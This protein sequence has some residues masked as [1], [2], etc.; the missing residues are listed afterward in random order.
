MT[1]DLGGEAEAPLMSAVGNVA[2]VSGTIKDGEQDRMKRVLF[3]V[4]RGKALSH[5]ND[6]TVPQTGERKSVYVV[7][8]AN[9][10]TMRDQVNKVCDSFLG[11]RFEIPD[12]SVI[13]DQ[14]HETK[15]DILKAQS[16]LDTSETQLRE[17]LRSI[18]KI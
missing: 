5:F 6:F 7:V 15:A 12:F 4:T 14:A 2:F 3:R 8:Y 11:Q 17:Y 10:K 18:N 16:L 1:H 13:Q 9:L